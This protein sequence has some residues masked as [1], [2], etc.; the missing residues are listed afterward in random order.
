[1]H[2]GPLPDRLGERT[3]VDVESFLVV[4]DGENV[5]PPVPLLGNVGG[6]GVA[7]PDKP[8]LFAGALV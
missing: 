8:V 1:M 3:L 6:D 2:A 5:P 4:D 7:D